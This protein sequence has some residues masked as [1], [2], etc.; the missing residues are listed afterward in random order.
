MPPK[1]DKKT[2]TTPAV[3][4]P[5]ATVSKK[6]EQEK[7]KTKP[8]LLKLT[9]FAAHQTPPSKLDNEGKPLIDEEGNEVPIS[10]GETISFYEKEFLNELCVSRAY[11]DQESAKKY[12]INPHTGN[13]YDSFVRSYQ[14]KYNKDN[15][16]KVGDRTISLTKFLTNDKFCNKVIAYYKA[17]GYECDIYQTGFDKLKNRYTKACVKVYF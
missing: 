5:T 12:L 6:K 7:E 4:K 2:P 17:L 3:P 14:F 11:M 10:F 9:F 1:T 8:K 15:S 16:V 13:P